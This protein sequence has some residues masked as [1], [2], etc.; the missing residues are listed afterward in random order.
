MIGIIA[1]MRV[2]LEKLLALTENKKTRSVSGLTFTQGVLEGVDVV[3]TVSGEG[4]VNAA[5]CAEAM[6]LLYAPTLLINTGVAGA[7][8]ATLRVPDIAVARAVKEHDYDISPLGYRKG[9]V[10]FPGGSALA[11]E[12]DACFADAVLRA[13]KELGVHAED[14]VIVSGD[15]F[16]ADAAVKERLVREF[17]GIA[18]EMEGG[19]IGH[20]AYLN[21]IPFGVIRAISDTADD[22]TKYDPDRAAEIS[23]ALTRRA[24]SEW[25]K[26]K[27]N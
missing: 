10:L 20:V 2:E 3:M 7:L 6:I 16:I 25:K 5:L 13:A 1:A 9:E 12:A 8:S 18:C 23:V 19:A 21:G 11:F 14:G 15:S 4:K 27:S 22:G 17:D 26:A 24:L